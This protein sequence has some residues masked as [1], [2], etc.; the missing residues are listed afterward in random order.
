MT[1]EKLK[2]DILNCRACVEKFGFDPVPVVRGTANSKIMQ[3]SQAPSYNVHLTSKP[4]NDASGNKLKYQWYKITDE[5]FYNEDNFYITAMA[6]CYPGK[7]P[8]GGDK[9]PPLSCAKKWL[10]KEMEFVDNKL[11]IIIGSYAS[12]FLFPKENFNDLIFKDNYID[13]KLTLVLPHPSPLNIRW[14]REH[15]EFEA[16]RLPYIREKVWSVL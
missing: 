16:E 14:F 10:L 3:I 8:K 15:P 2:Q 6:H 1:F 11:F 5:V 7:N 13:G 4:F 9:P 12:K